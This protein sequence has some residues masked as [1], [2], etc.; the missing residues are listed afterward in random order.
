MAN[1]IKHNKKQIE[2]LAKMMQ[3]E[4]AFD[5][6]FYMRGLTLKEAIEEA[7]KWLKSD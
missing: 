6:F 3:K 1:A 4:I 7:K 5:P 2:G